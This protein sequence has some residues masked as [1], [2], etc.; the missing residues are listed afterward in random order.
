MSG[1]ED[2]N[3]CDLL[4]PPMETKA[5][6]VVALAGYAKVGKSATFNP[7]TGV[8]QDFGNWPG[9]TLVRPE[10]LLLHPSRR[11]RVFAPP[12]IYPRLLYSSSTSRS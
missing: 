10:A 3:G 4:H 1:C 9:Q 7:L 12:S 5:E 11:I 8:G 6:Y 2:C